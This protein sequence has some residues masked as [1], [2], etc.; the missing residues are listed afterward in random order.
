MQPFQAHL[1]AYTNKLTW[2]D[3]SCSDLIAYLNLFRVYDQH[4]RLN[5]MNKHELY[6]WSNKNFLNYR[7]LQEW[8]VLVKEIRNR[9]S[10]IGV[11]ASS[12]EARVHVT[13][14]ELPLVLKVAIAGAFYPNYFKRTKDADQIDEREAVREVGGRD[15]FTTVYFK[16]M[17]S[18]QPGPLY[19]KRIKE[20]LSEISSNMNVSF[21]SRC[22]NLC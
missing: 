9:L 13:D 3:G 2:A 18:Q 6:K 17:D 16:N 7:C 19:A 1:R 4:K 14:S 20:S 8:E 21:E 11:V 10:T 15:P 5:N 22:V 12:G